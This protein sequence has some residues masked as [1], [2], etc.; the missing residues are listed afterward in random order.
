MVP[1]QVTYHDY[2]RL[3]SSLGLELEDHLVGR[4]FGVGGELVEV[5]LHRRVVGARLAEALELLARG[6]YI[7]RANHRER[8]GEV[9]IERRIDAV[10][11][12]SGDVD[13]RHEELLAFDFHEA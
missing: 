2:G 7:A 8:V 5:E 12:A 1:K 11:L 9:A 10:V 6:K 13:D 3:S 4:I